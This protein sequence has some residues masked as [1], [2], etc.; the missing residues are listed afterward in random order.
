MTNVSPWVVQRLLGMVD[1]PNLLCC[2]KRPHGLQSSFAYLSGTWE[3]LL[4]LTLCLG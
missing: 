4:T 3:L 2:C 1:W